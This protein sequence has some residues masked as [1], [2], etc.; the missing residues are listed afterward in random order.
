MLVEN[1]TLK[2]HLDVVFEQN[3]R[4]DKILI[5]QNQ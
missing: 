5:E 2:T 4:E 1:D 3:S